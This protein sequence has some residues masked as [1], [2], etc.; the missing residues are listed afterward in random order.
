MTPRCFCSSGPKEMVHTHFTVLSFSHRKKA[1]PCCLQ[2]WTDASGSVFAIVLVDLHARGAK[3]A[4]KIQLERERGPSA[5]RCTRHAHVA[6]SRGVRSGEAA[7]NHL[8]SLRT[9]FL[10][11][12]DGPKSGPHRAS[13]HARILSARARHPDHL[14]PLTTTSGPVG[15]PLTP[16]PRKQHP[17][18]NIITRCFNRW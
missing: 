16:T 14:R 2:N 18:K 3:G 12:V 13:E 8:S 9:C 17:P 1:L 15:P 5:C 10:W 7:H 11:G 4:S 6:W